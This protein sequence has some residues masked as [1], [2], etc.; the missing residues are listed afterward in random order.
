LTEEDLEAVQPKLA[1]TIE[2]ESFVAFDDTAPML[3]DK[4]YC[5]EPDKRDHKAYA[6]L[7]EALRKSGR[8]A[9]SKV[10]PRTGKSR[11]IA[12]KALSSRD[13]PHG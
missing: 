5:L 8:A 4:P 10:A 12:V 7:R 6:L 13:I 9:I 11:A 3:F 1:K 2:I